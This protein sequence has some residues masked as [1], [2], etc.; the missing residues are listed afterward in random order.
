MLLHFC[1]SSCV[2]SM[3]VISG[4][5]MYCHVFDSFVLTP[6]VACNCVVADG[7][8]SLIAPEL[9]HLISALYRPD[10]KNMAEHS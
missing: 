4:D 9:E 7:C 1:S 8:A 5:G 2:H 6:F 10:V 3:T